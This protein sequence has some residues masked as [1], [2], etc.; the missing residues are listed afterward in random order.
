[1]F[2][3][4]LHRKRQE[5]VCV[6]L[7]VHNDQGLLKNSGVFSHCMLASRCNCMINRCE[8]CHTGVVNNNNNNNNYDNV[9]GA[10]IM[11]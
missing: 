2:Y 6:W 10:V 3:F 4:C 9:Y 11:T 5:S 1:M 8:Y 7:F